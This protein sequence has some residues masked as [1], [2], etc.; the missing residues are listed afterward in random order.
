MQLMTKPC[1][2]IRYEIC[3]RDEPRTEE[4]GE[5]AQKE[6]TFKR[7]VQPRIKCHDYTSC[8][9]IGQSHGAFSP[10]VDRYR[11]VLSELLL[12]FMHLPNEIYKTLSGFGHPLFRPIGELEL[13]HGPGLSVLPHR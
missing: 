2:S 10:A 6:K 3:G 1:V 11:P 8:I 13:P 12:G 9:L 4:T 7:T 5:D